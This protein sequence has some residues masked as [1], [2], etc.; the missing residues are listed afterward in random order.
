M[1]TSH[2]LPAKFMELNEIRYYYPV[3]SEPSERS[4]AFAH[5]RIKKH[6]KILRKLFNSRRTNSSIPPTDPVSWVKIRMAAWRAFSN[7]SSNK[8]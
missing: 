7:S 2:L 3:G 8:P 1:K 6:R 5:S 4:A